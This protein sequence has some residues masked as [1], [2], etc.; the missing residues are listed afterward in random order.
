MPSP[1]LKVAIAGLGR[2]GRDCL[3]D[4]LVFQRRRVKLANE[5]ALL[6]LAPLLDEQRLDPAG[7]LG[8]NHGLVARLD[9]TLGTEKLFSLA[10]C[11]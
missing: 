1:K 7:D 11:H 6:D 8:A 2:M 5:I 4:Q 10:S 3:V 9:V